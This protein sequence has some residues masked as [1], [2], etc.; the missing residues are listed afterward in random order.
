MNRCRCHVAALLLI[1]LALGLDCLG[2]SRVSAGLSLRAHS[3]TLPA[4]RKAAMQAQA[5]CQSNLG[6][7][8]AVAGLIPAVASAACVVLAVGRRERARWRS[9]VFALLGCYLLL[10]F[11]L[12]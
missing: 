3:I 7:G 6:T 2:K 1:L 8:L 12:I 4:D 9:A 10:Q 11:V 5:R